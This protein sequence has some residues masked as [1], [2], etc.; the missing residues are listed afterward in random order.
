[1]P[2]L[3]MTC[4]YVI[5]FLILCG[6]ECRKSLGLVNSL[7]LL[8]YYYNKEKAWLDSQLTIYS[9]SSSSQ[10]TR[11]FTSKQSKPLGLNSVTKLQLLIWY[12]CHLPRIAPR[13]TWN[14]SV[15]IPDNEF[16][17]MPLQEY[18]IVVQEGRD[19]VPEPVSSS[20]DELLYN[21]RA[22]LINS[23]NS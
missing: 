23:A 11:D 1:M 12:S 3:H 8:L 5:D 7:L 19:S 4:S 16:P 6:L 14:H 21:Y 17:F 9:L 20:V 15:L 22:S 13:L 2:P 10:G 18:H